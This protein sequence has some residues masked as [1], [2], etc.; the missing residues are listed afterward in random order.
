MNK[1]I[2]M[3][4]VVLSV[5]TAFFVINLGE[6]SE[7]AFEYIDGFKYFVIEDADTNTYTDETLP[8]GVTSS[9]GRILIDSDIRDEAFKGCSKLTIV[10]LGEGVETIGRSAFE[11]CT[12][13]QTLLCDDGLKTIGS[14]AFK[15]SEIFNVHLPRTVTAIGPDAFSGCTN[16]RGSVLFGTS[17]TSIDDGTFRNSGVKVEDLRDVSFISS[18]AFSGTDLRV[19]VL[20]EGQSAKVSGVPAIYVHGFEIEDISI[21]YKVKN[22]IKDY[23][24]RMIVED[25]VSLMSRNGDGTFSTFNSKGEVWVDTDPVCNIHSEEDDLHLEPVKYTIH[26]E[27]YLGMDDVIR[28]SG[29]GTYVLPSPGIAESIFIGWTVDGIGGYV[30]QLTEADFQ[31]AGMLVEPIADYRTLTLTFD[32]SDVSSA[33]EYHGLPGS[34]SFSV[35]STYPSLDGVTGYTFSGWRDGGVFHNAGDRI[36]NYTNHTVRSVWNAEMFILTLVAADGTT[37]AQSVSAGSAVD[38]ASLPVNEPESKRFLGWSRAEN[39]TIMTENPIINSDTT[40]YSLFADR[41]PHTIRYLDG[42]TVIG[43]QAGYHGRTVIMD[44]DDPVKAG[45]VF[46]GWK[47]GDRFIE[48]GES[49]LMD[50][51]KEIVSVWNTVVLNLTYHISSNAVSSYDYGS[52]VIVDYDPGARMGYDFTGWSTLENGSVTYVNGDSF[53]IRNNIDLYPGWTANWKYVITIHDYLGRSVQAEKEPGSTFIIPNPSIRDGKTFTGWAIIN[54][55]EPIYQSGDSIRITDNTNLYET[56]SDI[57][58]VTVSIHHYDGTVDTVNVNS[59]SSYRIP[60]VEPREGYSFAGWAMSQNGNAVY[61]DGETILIGGDTGIYERWNALSTFK[62]TVHSEPSAEYEA[63]EGRTITV[64]LP[65]MSRT[66]YDHI[67]W[68]KSPGSDTAQYSAAETVTL[69]R[70]AD[71]YPIWKAKPQYTVTVHLT[72]KSTEYKIYAGDSVKLPP[73]LGA[74]EGRNHEGWTTNSDGTGRFYAPGSLLYP[75]ATMELYPFW[76]DPE[77]LKLI[78]SDG[79]EAISSIN[80]QKGTVFSFEDVEE[81]VRTG[82]GFLGWSKNKGSEDVDYTASDSLKMESSTTLF[83]VWERLVRITF[84]ENKIGYYHVNEPVELPKP[85]KEGSIFLGWTV[86]GSD[87]ILSTL[88]AE[89]DT[90]LISLWEAEPSDSTIPDD[91]ETDGYVKERTEIDSTNKGSGISVTTVGIGAAVAAAVSALIAIQIRRN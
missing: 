13:I 66:G 19:Q 31:T 25:S 87:D 72:E 20:S 41:E 71:L 70:S 23:S 33:P 36:T 52:I 85:E 24:L 48:N 58:S 83:A 74:S 37:S 76:S 26:F 86:K 1:T 28:R 91:G 53:E 67:G 57:V 35:N 14:S 21:S 56:W 89:K 59:G 55:G 9:G 61:R 27:D 43:Y 46:T 64:T 44:V 79:D 15:D 7:A 60:I 69:N 29:S 45:N 78:L 2:A 47:L 75:T 54:G 40:L 62:V 16:L 84:D 8:S 4:A 49:I 11:G 12:N 88:S 10:Y 63:Y 81:P 82:F 6:G 5:L 3:L 39:G 17:V 65:S 77:M 42:S 30:S 73:S 50:S 32:N 51:D 18:T 34:I 80:V 90:E 22:G 38:L 68:S